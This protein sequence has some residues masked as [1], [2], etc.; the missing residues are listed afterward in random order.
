MSVRALSAQRVAVLVTF[1]VSRKVQMLKSLQKYAALSSPKAK[2]TRSNR[3]GCAKGQLSQDYS[4]A[5][6]AAL[7]SAGGLLPYFAWIAADDHYDDTNLVV[8]ELGD[9]RCRVVA[10]DF[11]QAAK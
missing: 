8:D 9:G 7:R 1:R 5:E 4:S 3:V 11:E 10:V 6:K 2:V